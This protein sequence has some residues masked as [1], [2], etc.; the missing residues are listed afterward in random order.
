MRALQNWTYSVL[1]DVKAEQS[2]S[3]P[4]RS[5][6]SAKEDSD[7]GFISPCSASPSTEHESLLTT[8]PHIYVV[9][10]VSS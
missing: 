1:K 6:H 8:L 2:F 4:S 7:C 5:S 3:R 10:S 9:V